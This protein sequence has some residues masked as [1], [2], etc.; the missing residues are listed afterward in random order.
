MIYTYFHLSN[1]LEHDDAMT[2]IRT[3]LKEILECQQ[4]LI[5]RLEIVE[6]AIKGWYSVFS[7]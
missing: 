7:S 3:T 2:D 4:S 6:N 1:D 5:R